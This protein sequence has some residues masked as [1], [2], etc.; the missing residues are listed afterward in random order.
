VSLYHHLEKANPSIWK[1]IEDERETLLRKELSMFLTDRNSSILLVEVDNEVVGFSHGIIDAQID[2]IPQRV[3]MIRTV[4]MKANY[5]RQAIGSRLVFELCQF[6]Q[7]NN[8][9]EVS[10]GYIIGNHD[11]ERFWESL[12]FKPIRMTANASLT[13]IKEQLKRKEKQIDL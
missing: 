11:A 4:Y 13:T 1:Y 9:Q 3:G 5:R 2:R 12:G 10:V 8:V 6:F 7:K